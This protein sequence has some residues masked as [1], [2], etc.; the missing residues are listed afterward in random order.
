MLVAGCNGA[1]QQPVETFDLYGYDIEF[2]PPPPDWKRTLQEAGEEAMDLGLPKDR[3]V[4]IR[5]DHPDGQGHLA[6]TSIDQRVAEQDLKDK[7]GKLLHKKGELVELE[8]DQ[9]T[10]DAFALWV[11]KRDGEITD[12]KYV[13][14]DGTNAFRMLFKY[15]KEGTPEKG[16]QL[17]FTKNGRQYT[18]ALNVPA[19]KFDAALPYFDHLGETFKVKSEKTKGSAPAAT[20]KATPKS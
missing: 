5:F 6:I 10:L 8:N 4:A 7:E 3:I 20:P 11:V 18:I 1:K 16:A 13:K 17:H 15:N 2:A 19:E 12:Q 14:V 9:E